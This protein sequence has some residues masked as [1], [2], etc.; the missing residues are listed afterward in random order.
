MS[1]CV[2]I[3][4]SLDPSNNEPGTRADNDGPAVQY[5]AQGRFYLVRVFLSY[6]L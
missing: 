3:I 4:F 2:L 1:N 5:H 6:F